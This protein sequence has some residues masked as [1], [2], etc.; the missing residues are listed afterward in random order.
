MN[1]PIYRHP[2]LYLFTFLLLGL[3]LQLGPWAQQDSEYDFAISQQ[4]LRWIYDQHTIQPTLSIRLTE[5]TKQV[6]R[7]ED[8]CEIHIAGIPTMTLGEPS[9]LVIEPPNLCKFPPPGL[10][11][12]SESNLRKEVW[13]DYLDDSF[14]GKDCEVRGFFRI[15]TEHAQGSMDPANPNHVFEIHPV[16]HI[17]AGSSEVSFGGFIK[18]FAGMSHV[19]PE[20]A[21]SI[22]ADKALRVRYNSSAQQYEFLVQ[23]KTGNF[24]IVE[25]GNINRDWI[26][27]IE[28]GHSAIARVSPDGQSRASLKLYTLSGTDADAWLHA[29]EQGQ[30]S[31]RRILFHGLF[32]FDYFSIIKAV[33]TQ[34]GA[35]STD[36]GWRNVEFPMALVVFGETDVIPWEED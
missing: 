23:G 30:Q 33:R 13:P 3:V 20:T 19:K 11:E 6:H 2:A 35:W 27:T 21:A 8:D 18:A 24:A 17:K 29:V 34:S 31:S 10:T 28:G 26:R 4:F 22:I 12:T 7:L 36:K 14:M 1:K 25:V 5:R 32:T 15:Y 9:G 16:T